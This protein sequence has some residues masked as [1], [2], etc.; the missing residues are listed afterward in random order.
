[1]E[2]TRKSAQPATKG[3]SE[4]SVMAAA[5]ADKKSAE[6][7]AGTNTKVNKLAQYFRILPCPYTQQI[8][9]YAACILKWFKLEKDRQEALAA[10]L[11]AAKQRKP[12]SQA[13]EETP[14]EGEGDEQRAPADG[15][16]EATDA[17]P[18]ADE[19]P[20]PAEGE[21]SVPTDAPP[22]ATT[23]DQPPADGEPPPAAEAPPPEAP[24]DDAAPATEG[25]EGGAEPPADGAQEGAPAESAPAAPADVSEDKGP[26]VALTKPPILRVSYTDSTEKRLAWNLAFNAMKYYNILDKIL[27]E[28]SFYSE[29]P[30]Y[31]EE[32]FLVLVTLF[33]YTSRN[34]QRRTKSDA[35]IELL[36]PPE[37]EERPAKYA[38]RVYVYPP[39]TDMFQEIEKAIMAVSV[40]FAASVARIRVKEQVGSLRLLL[41]QEWREAENHA[42]VMPIYAWYNQLL[43]K[44]E[45]VTTWLKNNNFQK[46]N[47]RLPRQSEYTTDEYCSDVFVFNNADRAKLAESQIVR[48]KNLVIQ[49]RSHLVVL[50]AVLSHVGAGEEV[51]IA[52]TTSPWWG[53]HLEGLLANKFPTVQPVPQIRVSRQAKEDEDPKF[54][55]KAGSKSTKMLSDDFL[56]LGP[57]T[58]PYKNVRHVILEASDTRSGVCSPVDYIECENDEMAVLKDMWTPPGT[59]Q[60]ETKKLELI[61]R[62]TALLKHALKFNQAR[63][64]TFVSHSV[65]DEETTILAQKTMEYSNRTLVREAEA[66]VAPKKITSAPAFVMRLPIMQIFTEAKDA[67]DSGQPSVVLPSSAVRFPPSDESNGFFFCIFKKEAVLLKQDEEEEQDAEGEEAEEKGKAAKKKPKKGKK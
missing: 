22:P 4:F 15:G 18:A 13:Q 1:M 27:D 39:T 63:T 21:A 19:Q 57:P 46:V 34:Y 44:Q 10:A 60:K 67:L 51:L 42:D 33:D 38:G 66:A 23:D 36:P 16:E 40:H 52:N 24:G 7:Q 65:H 50:H 32:E 31:K 49:D 12:S 17:A 53:V 56:T 55:T 48:D 64:V 9:C 43:G 11:E 35:D 37:N 62:T 6:N 2:S 47:G 25:G 5:S 3:S 59:P 28:V 14:A 29:Y 41:P 45:I 20:V 8:F 61:Q 58:E 26:S 30:D 54:L